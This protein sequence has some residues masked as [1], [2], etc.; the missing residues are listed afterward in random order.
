LLQ[1]FCNRH[2]ER[3]AKRNQ[4]KMY[5][6]SKIIL[7]SNGTG[8]EQLSFLAA[9]F[10]IFLCILFG[11]NAVAVK[12]SLTG[13]GVFTTAGLRFS[14]AAILISLWALMTRRSMLIKREHALKLLVV[15][16]IFTTQLSFF[17][18]GLSKTNA[19][20][21]TLVANLLP[22]FIL[23]LAH[24][25]IPGDRITKRK[26]VGILLGFA[27]IIFLFSGDREIISRYLHGDLLILAAV[28]LWSCGTV[29]VKTIIIDFKPFHLVLFP[30]IFSVPV[31]FFEAFLWDGVMLVS[32]TTKVLAALFYQSVI[33]AA[34]GFVA[35]NTLLKRYEA[36]SL[37]SFVFV[38]PISGVFF[39]G[40]LLGDPITEN[41]TL[42]LLF[43]IAGILVV[44]SKI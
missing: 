5:K 22:F 37:N 7:T 19:A 43:I 18:L 25:F 11:A 38:M 40:L 41:I 9:L 21:G 2:C 10:T 20:R 12:I 4:K 34:F 30:M 42:S 35:W 31:F 15:S 36:S 33:T 8:N 17:Y 6:P 28:I 26:L 14:I 13:L 3:I 23:F 29:Y 16:I 32:L 1:V 39:G 24:W 44:H 27:G